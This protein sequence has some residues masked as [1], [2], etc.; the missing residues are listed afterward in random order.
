MQNAPIEHSAILFTFIKL[1][2]VFKTFVLSIFERPPKTG[3]TVVS[4]IVDSFSRI[5]YTKYNNKAMHVK[6]KDLAVIK[7][8]FHVNI[9]LYFIV[10]TNCSLTPHFNQ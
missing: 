4:C 10:V 5:Q 6:E 7:R 2:F 1:P 3:F 9:Q 8:K